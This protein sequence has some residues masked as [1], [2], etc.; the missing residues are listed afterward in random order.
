MSSSEISLNYEQFVRVSIF[1]FN[2][3]TEEAEKFDAINVNWWASF[4]C[5]RMQ[6]KMCSTLHSRTS[7][8]LSHCLYVCLSA[9]I[10]DRIRCWLLIACAKNRFDRIYE[11]NHAR[12]NELLK[13]HKQTKT[14]AQRAHNETI[15]SVSNRR[16]RIVTLVRQES[17]LSA[18]RI[19][20][21]WLTAFCGLIN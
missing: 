15:A 1:A 2:Y 16:L 12:G 20:L 21:V 14:C 4:G 17:T 3:K 19:N 7:F 8:L 18:D 10:C 5:A 13:Y 9:W 11:L 6:K